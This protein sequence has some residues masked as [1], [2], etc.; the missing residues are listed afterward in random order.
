MTT[1]AQKGRFEPISEGLYGFSTSGT[2]FAVVRH[3]GKLIRRSLETDDRALAKRRLVDFRRTLERVDHKAGKI[4]VAELAARHFAT[5]QH[6]RKAA[7]FPGVASR[8]GWSVNGRE[9][10]Q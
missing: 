1:P 9:V 6:R 8:P 3:L 10:L 5:I 4:T 2:Y 7:S